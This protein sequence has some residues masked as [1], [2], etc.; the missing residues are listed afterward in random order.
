MLNI[1]HASFSRKTEMTKTDDKLISIS[2]TE[3]RLLTFNKVLP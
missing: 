2:H 3:F 1:F